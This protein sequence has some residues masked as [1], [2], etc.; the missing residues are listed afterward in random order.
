MNKTFLLP[1]SFIFDDSDLIDNIHQTFLD[2]QV[3]ADE[4]SVQGFLDEAFSYLCSDYQTE[5]AK[6]LLPTISLCFSLYPQYS[7]PFAN[8]FLK[9]N[10]LNEYF[11]ISSASIIYELTNNNIQIDFQDY[12]LFVD[13]CL[14]EILPQI[15]NQDSAIFTI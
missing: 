8:K 13:D 12:H 9:P 5:V 6:E 15:Q 7:L 11:I 4:Q 14:K 1:N 2:L 10:K 3:S